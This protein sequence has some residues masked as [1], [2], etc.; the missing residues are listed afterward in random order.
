MTPFGGGE[1]FLQLA[2]GS[3][4]ATLAYRT[5]DGK[6]RSIPA[7]DESVAE[8][9]RITQFIPSPRG[10]WIAVQYVESGSELSELRF[11][12]FERGQFLPSTFGPVW[13]EFAAAWHPNGDGVFFT[14]MDPSAK[15]PMQG[16]RLRYWKFGAPEK[17]VTDLV[18]A[19]EDGILP[20]QFPLAY[21]PRGSKW[22]IV[23]AANANPAWELYA[24]RLSD[25]VSG[26]PLQLRKVVG[27]EDLVGRDAFAVRGDELFIISG[28]EAPNGQIEV[29]NLETGTRETVLAGEEH[30][31]KK[32]SATREH[33]YA[34]ALQDGA[35]VL[36]RCEGKQCRALPMPLEGAWVERL[37]SWEDASELIL[38][39]EGLVEPRTYFSIPDRGPT[40]PLGIGSTTSV[41]LSQL[42]TRRLEATSFDGARVPMTIVTTDARRP[43]PTLMKAYGAY[44]IYLQPSFVPSTLAWV[45]GG[46]NIIYCHVRGGGAKGIAWHQ[47]GS[48]RNK[49][50]GV[51]DLL[52]CA[53]LAIQEGLTT[54]DMMAVEG[55]SIGGLLVGLAATESPATFAVVGLEGALLNPARYLESRNGANAQEEM[56]ATPDTAEGLAFLLSIDPYHRLRDKEPYPPMFF[57]IPL[58]DQRVEPW[59]AAKFA[60][61]LLEL[62]DPKAVFIVTDDEAHGGAS[63]MGSWAEA[64]ARKWAF[65]LSVIEK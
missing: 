29:V 43:Q 56:G 1:L 38:S 3:D 45:E 42:H 61:R 13:A 62:V 41:D 30:A 55:G 25:A 21:A 32:L 60:A 39:Q 31:L 57:R 14:Q 59:S 63:S 19:G 11:L 15:D 48:G 44:G 10:R 20:Q 52:A 46:R 33:V 37:F 65:Y 28:K 58:R 40:R 53:E 64:L 8:G 26:R 47:A 54:S 17:S 49:M 2:A 36:F 4:A 24:I 22:L 9:K 35:S 34:H 50:K 5:K 18:V 16:M 6:K 27:K 12:D 51:R 7:V 23:V